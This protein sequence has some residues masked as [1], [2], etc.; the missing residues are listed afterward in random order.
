VGHGWIRIK[1]NVKEL[2][3]KEVLFDDGTSAPVDTIIHATGYKTRFPFIDTSVF[4]VKDNEVALYRRMVA[5]DRPGLYF[6]G[7]V[8]PIG[9]TIPLVEIQG[10]W[11]AG[12][13]AGTVK[14]PEADAMQAEIAEHRRKLQARYVNSARYTLEVDFR[15]HSRELLQDLAGR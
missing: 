14:L 12:V 11:I 8:Q 10:R 1:P 15:E 5:A 13:L 7:L 2:R 6:L 4:E 3:G 9:P